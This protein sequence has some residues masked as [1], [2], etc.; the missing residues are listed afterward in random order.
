MPT[1]SAPADAASD[2]EAELLPG[3]LPGWEEV[4]DGITCRHTPVQG[5]CKDGWC[6]IPPGC[7]VKGSPID[8]LGHPATVE[9]QVA[10]ILTRGFWIQQY[11]VT[12]AQWTALALHNP[13]GPF[14]AEQG[15][16]CT[17]DPRCPVGNLT[18]FEAVAFANLLSE[19]QQ[20]PLAPC[21]A[22]TG[23]T[24]ELG[25]K[26][27]CESVALTAPTLYE[28]ESYR[29]PSDAEWEYAVRA[30][31]R[32]AFYSGAIVPGAGGPS[33][34]EPYAPLVD[35]AWYCANS[36]RSTHPVGQKHPNAWHLFDMT[37]NA[38]EWVHDVENGKA[39]PPGPLQ[40]PGG[41][42]SLYAYRKARGGSAI[43]WPTVLRSAASIGYP[44]TSPRPT[45]GFRLV[46]TMSSNAGQPDGG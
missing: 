35:I 31:T 28:C 17:D 38:A 25:H 45:R 32:T 8:E 7:F 10:V 46:R 30:S 41:D 15:G 2:S 34:C 44:W 26:M 36:G 1:N 9:N 42:L 13:S 12:Q 27:V 3:P 40:D 16:D 39:P 24:G 18:W 14:V 29:L 43:G 22:L 11:E 6:C 19:K 4:W 21:Y 33:E 23:C 5:D 37:G 20:P